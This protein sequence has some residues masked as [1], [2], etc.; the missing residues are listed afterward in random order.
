MIIF[1]ESGF[2]FF[3]ILSYGLISRQFEFFVS[4]S[5][6]EIHIIFTTPGKLQQLLSNILFTFVCN[7]LLQ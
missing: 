7:S 1:D 3:H 5:R 6:R 2:I 4:T